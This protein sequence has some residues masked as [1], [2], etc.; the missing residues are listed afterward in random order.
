MTERTIPETISEAELGHMILELRK[1]CSEKDKRL[2]KEVGLSASEYNTLSIEWPVGGMN[3]KDLAHALNMTPSGAS[4]IAQSLVEHGVLERR[5]AP[6]DRRGIVL[7]LSQK[8]IELQS[9]IRQ[10][11]RKAHREIFNRFTPSQH[12]PVL[13]GVSLLIQALNQW[14]FPESR[15][16]LTDPTQNG[17]HHD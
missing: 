7:S 15:Q 11:T 9:L 17:D 13:Q 16:L 4:R 8:G 5:T 12:R 1:L 3:L 6:R 2:I 10:E 14:L